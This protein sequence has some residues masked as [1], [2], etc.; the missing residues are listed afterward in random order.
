MQFLR[1]DLI[2]LRISF[3]QFQP[4]PSRSTD[5]K[6][7]HEIVTVSSS[8]GH[9]AESENEADTDSDSKDST[10]KKNGSEEESQSSTTV[11]RV[12]EIMQNWN[13]GKI[14]SMSKLCQDIA[15]QLNV[16]FHAPVEAEGR[17]LGTANLL[18]KVSFLSNYASDVSNSWTVDEISRSVT[19]NLVSIED[20]A[21]LAE[22]GVTFAQTNVLMAPAVNGLALEE[23]ETTA[24]I[25]NL[26][27]R[28][29]PMTTVNRLLET[30][31]VGI[32]PP[33]FHQKEWFLAECPFTGNHFKVA[34]VETSDQLH[35]IVSFKES[36]PANIVSALCGY[37]IITRATTA[38][39]RS[40]FMAALMKR[41]SLYDDQHCGVKMVCE[42]FCLADKASP[43]A[44]NLLLHCL[45]FKQLSA[46]MNITITELARRFI[47]LLPANSLICTKLRTWFTRTYGVDCSVP[48]VQE[49]DASIRHD[50]TLTPKL[51]ENQDSVLVS[52]LDSLVS[53][54]SIGSGSAT[55]S[56]GSLSG[57]DIITSIRTTEYLIGIPNMENQRQRWG[58]AMRRLAQ[59]VYQQ[60]VHV[61]YEL[62]Q[63]ADDCGFASDVSPT[64]HFYGSDEGLLVI[65]NEIGLSERDARALC[66]IALSTKAEDALRTTGKFGIGFKSVFM[67]TDNPMV[68]DSN[69]QFAFISDD[70][71]PK[72]VKG[73][74][75]D[76]VPFVCPYW[77]EG[78]IEELVPDVLL[79]LVKSHHGRS[80]LELQKSGSVIWLPASIHERKKLRLKELV[81]DYMC[82][83]REDDFLFLRRMHTI[84]LISPSSTGV[85]RRR[86]QK[87]KSI[88][89]T[90][91]KN[92]LL[93]HKHV[94]RCNLLMNSESLWDIYSTRCLCQSRPVF[95]EIAFQRGRGMVSTGKVYVGLPVCPSGLPFHINGN[96][97]V[98]AT[99]E[100]LQT[101]ERINI[102]LRDMIGDIATITFLEIQRDESSEFES[103]DEKLLA[104]LHIVPN[105]AKCTDFFRPLARRVAMEINKSLLLPVESHNDVLKPCFQIRLFPEAL[106]TDTGEEKHQK[107][108]RAILSGILKKL[109]SAQTIDFA[110]CGI[111]TTLKSSAYAKEL[112][113]NNV[114][115]L[116]EFSADDIS[117]ILKHTRELPDANAR[118]ENDTIYLILGLLSLLP[119][120]K[121]NPSLKRYLREMLPVKLTDHANQ[122]SS[123]EGFLAEIDR[124]AIVVKIKGEKNRNNIYQEVDLASNFYILGHFKDILNSL[125]SLSQSE[126]ATSDIE[127]VTTQLEA[128]TE[129]TLEEFLCIPVVNAR[130]SPR[131]ICRILKHFLLGDSC[132]PTQVI[133]ITNYIAKHAPNWIA[134][135]FSNIKLS[136]DGHTTVVPHVKPIWAGRK[137]LTLLATHPKL[138]AALQA[139][140]WLDRRYSFSSELIKTLEP[141]PWCSLQSLNLV[142]ETL[143]ALPA[144]DNQD[145]IAA[146]Y[147]S[148]SAFV[149]LVTWPSMRE[150]FDALRSTAHIKL[151]GSIFTPRAFWMQGYTSNITSNARLMAIPEALLP[152]LQENPVL[153]D[154]LG[155]HM[156]PTMEAIVST[157]N[158]LTANKEGWKQWSTCMNWLSDKLE[159][160]QD[161]DFSLPNDFR[162]LV[163]TKQKRVLKRKPCEVI[164]SLDDFRDLEPHLPK[165]L[166]LRHSIP[167]GW[168]LVYSK[169]FGVS[170]NASEKD[171]TKR[172]L[173]AYVD[174]IKCT[175][176]ETVALLLCHA[177]NLKVDAEW[178][179]FF[180]SF[181]VPSIH[182]CDAY[183]EFLDRP[184]TLKGA[185]QNHIWVADLSDNDAEAVLPRVQP[186]VLL[187]GHV[188]S[189]EGD[190]LQSSWTVLLLRSGIPSWR[191][192]LDIK[193]I[194]APSEKV[195]YPELL[196]H[197]VRNCFIT[198]LL[199]LLEQD[200]KL[201]TEGIVL[202]SIIDNRLNNF[203]VGFVQSHQSLYCRY[204]LPPECEGMGK[205]SRSVLE[206]DPESSN[207][208]LII[209]V[210]DI[211]KFQDHMLRSNE[212]Q[213]EL[214]P[215]AFYEMSRLFHPAWVPSPAIKER[216]RIAWDVGLPMA[217]HPDRPVPSEVLK[218]AAIQKESDND[219]WR[220]DLEW[221]T[222]TA[223]KND[224]PWTDTV[225]GSGTEEAVPANM[226]LSDNDTS[227]NEIV[228]VGGFRGEAIP[229]QDSVVRRSGADDIAAWR[230]HRRETAECRVRLGREGERIVY[231]NLLEEM[232]N[233]VLE[234][235]TTISWINENKESGEPY[236]ILVTSGLPSNP[237]ETF[238]EVKATR[239][240]NKQLFEFSAMEW[241]FSQLKGNDYH[242]YR[243]Y[244]GDENPSIV[245]IV[246]PYK[247]WRE[248]RIGMML[249]M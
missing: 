218:S 49:F 168:Q 163:M 215:S 183:G 150:V 201:V 79:Q 243:L 235:S 176:S 38:E 249:A 54:D 15:S 230:S 139:S 106:L 33:L 205:F 128:L 221:G 11:N 164:W 50:D 153:V 94:V 237:H 135:I 95:A 178:M 24:L 232:R 57:C 5:Q 89:E 112:M 223:A 97:L 219:I 179:N 36:Q 217:L 22:S 214:P 194:R 90:C 96:F 116:K 185:I 75:A 55:H 144:C 120:L 98:A 80:L 2:G 172:L 111:E 123:V 100:G 10:D 161:I 40:L 85:I 12:K 99:R 65:S 37:R 73:D 222:D 108:V 60:D 125:L 83:P 43:L 207:C 69:F 130:S 227:W 220:R 3:K 240:Q 59:D 63:N 177:G 19:N 203:K 104:Q 166:E 241:Q 244:F 199:P 27:Q 84:H 129:K 39:I 105:P 23:E 101:S 92:T 196:T 7:V 26:M 210:P 64:I 186:K 198:E 211:T 70:P 46:A 93:I 122:K 156:S 246:N 127:F 103:L 140:E 165:G 45:D 66:D 197:V 160:E 151:L 173:D 188:N 31:N 107:L 152:V 115:V 29:P 134:M 225:S 14:N 78:N 234:G 9:S 242:I 126:W 148:L 82:D 248:Q 147:E 193:H 142:I 157:M 209:G 18:T 35:L 229:I 159:N 169:V 4:P 131:Q 224:V 132:S 67:I 149:D 42:T 226:S 212:E 71:G 171:T 216:A 195:L 118:A 190:R 228:R 154:L 53:V 247:Q 170:M 47:E 114:V 21:M 136:R 102:K 113:D 48:P 192:A 110:K 155:I 34:Y 62:L 191:S 88:N 13:E 68:F 182:V 158:L 236:D 87:A 72:V 119:T 8:S 1:C 189:S 20:G 213:I 184:V 124:P 146:M 239:S 58:R 181:E 77:V 74:S 208:V 162:L 32:V 30:A 202:S 109:N 245:R 117:K 91:R 200:P 121:K 233:Q 28:A 76:I 180:S 143:E 133:T 44:T 86:Y 238:I 187:C 6:E 204:R 41:I 137:F 52:E 81:D 206:H 231:A 56:I 145:F 138:Y 25:T 16:P 61:I 175:E 174:D 167:T 17:G 141:D 51:Y